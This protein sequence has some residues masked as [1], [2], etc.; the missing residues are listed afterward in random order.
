MFR[1]E[2]SREGKERRG[3]KETERERESLTIQVSNDSLISIGQFGLS[4][5]LSMTCTA[6]GNTKYDRNMKFIQLQDNKSNHTKN[7][8]HA[9]A[10]KVAK[11]AT[12]ELS[13]VPMIIGQKERL[14]SHQTWL[15][16]GASVKRIGVSARQV[17]QAILSL[18]SSTCPWGTNPHQRPHISKS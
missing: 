8:A 4:L 14:N 5:A 2:T 1:N 10:P 7:L 18:K 16:C 6:C 12:S 13:N 17:L 11:S 15:A 3:G 9:W